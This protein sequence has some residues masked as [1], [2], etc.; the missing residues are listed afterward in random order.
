MENAKP[1]AKDRKGQQ[2]KQKDNQNQQNRPEGQGRKGSKN[3]DDKEEK[4]I[5]D[6]LSLLKQLA[7]SQPSLEG[8]EKLLVKEGAK[9]EGGTTAPETRKKTRRGR[10]GKKNRN[11]GGQD[12]EMEELGEEEEDDRHS[13]G[14]EQG[15]GQRSR[16]RGRGQGRGRGRSRGGRGRQAWAENRRKEDDDND[17]DDDDDDDSDSESIKSGGNLQCSWEVGLNYSSPGKR[18]GHY[19]SRDNLRG[20]GRGGRGR[21]GRGGSNIRGS[22]DGL[23]DQNE[24]DDN[25][26][27]GID[28]NE[29]FKYLVQNYGGMVRFSKFLKE[30]DI[31]PSE[32]NV[33]RWFR[34]H[35]R[36]FHIFEDKGEILFIAPFY[37]G[38]T[39][40]IDYAGVTKKKGGCTRENCEHFHICQHYMRGFCRMQRCRKSHS[41]SDE[42]NERNKIKLGLDTFTDDQISTILINRYPQMC[43]KRA[44]KL[45]KQCPYLHI[46]VRFLQGKCFRYY[47]FVDQE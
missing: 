12:D 24:A 10:G 39:Y 29:V 31:F 1:Q 25:D 3:E 32:A 20:R 9:E 33:G 35:R 4:K 45:V 41:Y 37:K 36:R 13:V 30:N 18:G 17:D 26:D 14:G 27:L 16:G 28:E 11:V 47:I 44:C 38:A 2:N 42:H 40:C 46:C 34:S 21:G 22:R 5:D 7:S 43:R 6:A 23:N 19:G 8:L 15:Q